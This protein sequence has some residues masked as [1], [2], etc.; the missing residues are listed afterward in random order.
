MGSTQDFLPQG[1]TSQLTM[2]GGVILMLWIA[3]GLAV[4][5]MLYL[6]IHPLVQRYRAWSVESQADDVNI[7]QTPVSVGPPALT[8]RDYLETVCPHCGT[9]VF[10]P[11]VRRCKPFFCPNCSQTN[12]PVKKQAF[13]WARKMLRKLLYPSFQDLF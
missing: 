2:N 6:V 7:P 4:A 5:F 10:V 1:V 9:T 8:M 12:P 3:G 11:K 13:A